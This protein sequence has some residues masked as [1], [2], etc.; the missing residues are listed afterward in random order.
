MNG[1][2]MVQFGQKLIEFLTQPEKTDE[3]GG[4]AAAPL[5][6]KNFGK[7]I[8]YNNDKLTEQGDLTMAAIPRYWQKYLKMQGL[9]LRIDGDELLPSEVER[10]ELIEQ[11][12]MWRFPLVEVTVLNKERYSLR[13]QRH[14][15]IAHVLKSVITLRGDYGRSAKNNHS[16]TMCLQLQADAGAVDGEQDLRHYRVQ[17]LYKILLRLVDYSSWRLV[18]P[19]DRQEDTI[20]VTVEL[21]KCCQREQ[22]VGHVCLTSGPVLEP[23]NMG[24]SFMTANEYLELRRRHMELMATQRSGMCPVGMSGLETLTKR[25]G[26][27]AVI[28]DLFVVRHSSAVR[29]V[30]HGMGICKGA[31]YILYNSARMEALL[32]K[33]HHEVSTGAYEKLPLLDEIDFSVLEDGV[34]WELVY[35][36]LLTFPELMECTMEQLD[37][38]NCGVHLLVHF[39]ENLAAAFSRFYY[40]KKVLLQKREELMPILYA[41]IYLIK[42]VRQVMNTALAVLGIEPVDYV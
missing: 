10:Q 24:A 19:N 16:R 36:Y 3:S 20:C 6:L 4:D 18:E 25:L 21:E 1:Y 7:L 13:F 23:M 9:K 35:G 40:H 42:A 11:S 14:P 27:A 31:S 29:V 15:I 32:R 28:V 12:R 34:D 41:R 30:R 2:P 33:F 22:P 39:V 5:P 26:A 8:R 37:Q 17:Q 38:G